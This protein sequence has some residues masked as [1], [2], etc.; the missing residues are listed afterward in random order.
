MTN[1]I[2][3]EIADLHN[4]ISS[5]K[6]PREYVKIDESTPMKSEYPEPRYMRALLNRFFPTASWTC[7]N[8]PIFAPDGRIIEWVTNGMLRW[9]YGFLGHPGIIREGSMSASHTIQYL[10]KDPN[11][12]SDM[13]NDV[14][15]SNTDCWKKALNFYLNICDDVYRWE[16]PELTQMEKD[17][18]TKLINNSTYEDKEDRLLILE[19]TLLVNKE[20]LDKMIMLYETRQKK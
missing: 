18:I 12:L 11:R 7:S 10:K 14:K 15:A 2:Y 9:D 19:N 4:R 13:G 16:S 20:N 3:K 8:T 6:T 5:I 1:Q 17:K